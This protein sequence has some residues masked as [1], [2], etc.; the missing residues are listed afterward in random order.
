MPTTAN[1]RA[2][3]HAIDP[4][5][6]ERW[7]PRAFSDDEISEAE[8]LSLFEAARW[9]PSSYNSQP[10]RFIYARRRTAHWQRL[11][12]LL[13]AFNA[14]W[15]KDSAALVVIVSKSTLVVPGKAEEIAS[16][17]HSFDAGAAWAHLALQATRSGWQA[18][19]MAG[20]DLERAIVELNVPGDY[21][22]EAAVAIGK[23][24]DKAQLPEALQAREVPSQ[25]NPLAASVF[26]G[27][28]PA[29]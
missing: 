14:S 12:G 8:L 19:G 7:S 21:R 28:F 2:A 23:V 15:A 13:N 4:L 16:H 18:H 5:F 9:A 1:D 25:R 20:L 29:G 11:L 3:D 26:E 10:W 6:L 24:G 17:T 22:V 27:A